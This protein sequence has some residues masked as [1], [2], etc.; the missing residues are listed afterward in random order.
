[1]SANNFHYA[2]L[3]YML[4]K[5]KIDVTDRIVYIIQSKKEHL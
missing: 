4:T 3:K 2:E 5:K 1:M